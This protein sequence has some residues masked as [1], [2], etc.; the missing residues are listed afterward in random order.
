MFC[1]HLFNVSAGSIAIKTG[2]RIA[3]KLDVMFSYHTQFLNTAT[4]YN[5]NTAFRGLFD[6]TWTYTLL[7]NISFTCAVTDLNICSFEI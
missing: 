1:F 3:F 5:S 4:S 6:S 7:F 2:G